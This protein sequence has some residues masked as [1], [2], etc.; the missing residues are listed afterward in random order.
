M[1]K[2]LLLALSLMALFGIAA[3]GPNSAQHN[4]DGDSFEECRL[5]C[6]ELGKSVNVGYSKSNGV[7]LCTNT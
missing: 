7:C 5:K 3:C 4:M 6:E 1:K 2:R